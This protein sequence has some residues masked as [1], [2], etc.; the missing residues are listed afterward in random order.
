LQSEGIMAEKL[1][2]GQVFNNHDQIGSI[3]KMFNDKILI[4]KEIGNER[5]LIIETLIDSDLFIKADPYALERV[6]NNLIENAF[7]YT[8]ENGRISIALSGSHKVVTM[9]VSDKGTGRGYL[10]YCRRE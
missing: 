6:I 3:S 7:E 9:T 4:F 10:V 8:H 5:N 1:E 2:R